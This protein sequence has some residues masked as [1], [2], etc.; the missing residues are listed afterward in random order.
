MWLIVVYLC[1]VVAS[2]F[3]C[4][5]DTI[6]RI[7]WYLHGSRRTLGP[8]AFISGGEQRGHWRH[9]SQSKPCWARSGGGQ[10]LTCSVCTDCFHSQDRWVFRYG[11]P[12]VLGVGA[13]EIWQ[14]KVLLRCWFRAG[15]GWCEFDAMNVVWGSKVERFQVMSWSWDCVSV[16]EDCPV[17]CN[18]KAMDKFSCLANELSAVPFH[19]MEL[20]VRNDVHPVREDKRGPLREWWD[21]DLPLKTVSQC[22]LAEKIRTYFSAG[23]EKAGK[24]FYVTARKALRPV[25]PQTGKSRPGGM[26]Q[27]MPMSPMHPKLVCHGN[28]EKLADSIIILGG[29]LSMRGMLSSKELD[30]LGLQNFKI[31][32]VQKH[33]WRKELRE[34]I[35]PDLCRFWLGW[36]SCKKFAVVQKVIQV[37]IV[38]AS[39]G[40]YVPDFED[41]S[42]SCLR[43]N[44]VSSA[45]NN[46]RS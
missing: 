37:M 1:F 42:F 24:Q 26:E 10:D 45:V 22:K 27:Y 30:R 33:R 4:K 41:Q 40:T 11:F 46:V 36:D 28:C 32:E 44:R 31:S 38:T 6:S 43:Y 21:Q 3:L 13:T 12:I 18:V 35:V 7:G 5:E 23:S 8:L 19:I 25:V 2:T 16:E 15:T 29:T 17:L 39:G 14:K 9:G 20:V 34:P